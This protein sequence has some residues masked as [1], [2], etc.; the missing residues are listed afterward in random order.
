MKWLVLLLIINLSLGAQ[1]KDYKLVLPWKHQF[2]FAGYYMAK[3]KG[4]YKDVNLN[5]NIK[6][7]TLQGDN[8]KDVA[9]GKYEFGVGHSSLILDKISKYQNILFLNAIHQSS[10]FVLL[11]I[12]YKNVEDIVGKKVMM[13]KDQSHTASINAMLY[14][15]Q[16]KKDSYQLIDTDFTLHN[17]I[18]SQ[19]DF[20]E[21]YISNEPYALKKKGI[22]S[23]VLDPKDYGYDFYGDILFTS[24]EMIQDNKQDVDNFILTSLQGWKYAYEHIDE[25]IDVIM[26]HYNTQNRTKS[27]LL[28][29]ANALKKLAFNDNVN[30]GDIN[31]RKLQEITTIYR[32]LG[33]LENTERIDFKTFIYGT[34][35]DFTFI[36]NDDKNVT[37]I[38]LL[39]LDN[40]Y[41]KFL[42]LLILI[43]VTLSI[44]FNIRTKKLLRKREKEIQL[45]NRI[46]DKNICSSI[47]D[48]NG[49]IT[50]VSEA[51]CTL[52][53]YSKE[54]LIHQTHSIF[55]DATTPN[56]IYKDLWFS[57]LSGHTWKGEMQN[58]KKD[59]TIYW[60]N[61]IITP[62]VNEDDSLTSF[63]AIVQDITLKKVLEE[64]NHK[65]EKEVKK[66]T[67]ILEQL[68]M[69]D[70][71][72]GL[73]N[74]L[75]I[76]E[77]LASNYTNF[78]KFNE[79]FS[80][81]IIDIDHFKDVNDTYGHQ[82]GD[83]ILQ[84]VTKEIKNSIRLTDTLGRWGGEEFM[85]ICPL[86]D[87]EK[88]YE[89][90]HKIRLAI[91]NYTFSRVKKLTISAGVSDIIL[92]QDV[93]QM[94]SYADTVLYN[95][96]HSGRNQVGR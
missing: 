10:P 70:K 5:I 48:K 72:T 9:L 71:L 54:E 20:M 28:F 81:I 95:A 91:E 2:Q 75:K 35:N 22:E 41:F 49:K 15:K 21:A 37:S 88:A 69:T 25:T 92:S 44:F 84:E 12:K 87:K 43:I 1:I 79:N 86:T 68:A 6:E 94:V 51:F 80:V 63:E 14:T 93:E 18:S 96:K 8:V 62:I 7:Y 73:Y 64:F 11:S 39:I 85:V 77:D 17:L 34:P 53:G 58:V 24:Q 89:V 3:E 40:I 4:F 26:K 13:S 46:F 50:H 78:R 45:Q 29:E 59:K 82:V 52:T 55:R 66:Q 19:V 60:I 61:L 36:I 27:A 56:E 42:F 33:L 23:F 65:L 83:I 67:Y 74:R 32:L 31:H 47:T 76:D 57:I 16:I 90:A 38:L 30:F